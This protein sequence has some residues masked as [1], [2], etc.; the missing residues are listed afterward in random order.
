MSVTEKEVGKNNVV[1][2][3]GESG[4]MDMFCKN[5]QTLICQKGKIL[6]SQGNNSG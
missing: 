2:H 4:D 3:N 6:P 1:V 5:N